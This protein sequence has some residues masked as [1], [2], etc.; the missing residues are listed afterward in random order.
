MCLVNTDLRHCGEGTGNHLSRVYTWETHL[1]D[2]LKFGWLGPEFLIQ[3]VREGAQACAHLT[4]SLVLL[5]L[6]VQGPQL[7]NH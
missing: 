7:E 1:E 6:L 5:I 2:W 4:G 3:K